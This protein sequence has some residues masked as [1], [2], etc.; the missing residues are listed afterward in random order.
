MGVLASFMA[1]FNILVYP[2]YFYY[3]ANKERL[4]I[5]SREIGG[6]AIDSINSDDRGP[7]RKPIIRSNVSS[8]IDVIQFKGQT[9]D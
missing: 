9:K 8:I 6:N 4:R 3:K 5:F 2:G 1:A 7:L